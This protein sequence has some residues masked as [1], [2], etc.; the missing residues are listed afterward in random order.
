[1]LHKDKKMKVQ[2]QISQLLSPYFNTANYYEYFITW[3]RW[4]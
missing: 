4:P 3:Q 2:I 1:M